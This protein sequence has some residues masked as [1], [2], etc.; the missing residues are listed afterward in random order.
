[1]SGSNN[2]GGK[3]AGLTTAA[4]TIV[5]PFTGGHKVITYVVLT[6]LICGI[7]VLMSKL[8]KRVVS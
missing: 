5:L 1:M 3:G 8:I 4:S 7:V 6:A 2:T